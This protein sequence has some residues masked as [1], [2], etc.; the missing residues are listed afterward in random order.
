MV[1]ISTWTC[2]TCSCIVERSPDSSIKHYE[3]PSQQHILSA[4]NRVLHTLAS[5]ADVCLTRDFRLA[6]P[7]WTCWNNVARR[8]WHN[9]RVGDLFW[10]RCSM[11]GNV[12]KC[13]F[14]AAILVGKLIDWR[15]VSR[16]SRVICEMQRTS[17]TCL[18]ANVRREGVRTVDIKVADDLPTF[19]TM[20]SLW[21]RFVIIVD[22]F[23]RT[24]FRISTRCEALF[25]GN[26]GTIAHA[27]AVATCVWMTLCLTY[28]KH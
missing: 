15:D 10:N 26:R 17:C 3:I 16:N 8:S 13:K 19:L 28:K 9:K 6:I 23:T 2:F 21:L 27:I 22:M 4:D 12:T 20:N 11:E 7:H 14:W 24:W 5:T 1:N 25:S 18:D